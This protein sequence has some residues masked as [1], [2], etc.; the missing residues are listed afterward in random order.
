MILREQEGAARAALQVNRDAMAREHYAL[1]LRVTDQIQIQEVLVNHNFR[2][3]ELPG[4]LRR[5]RRLRA[6]AATLGSELEA[7][8]AL[9]AQLEGLRLQ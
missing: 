5:T 3:P 7:V 1:E 4:S 2:L 9:I 8:T 6:E